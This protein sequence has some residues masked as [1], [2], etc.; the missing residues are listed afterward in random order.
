MIFLKAFRRHCIRLKIVWCEAARV[1][2]ACSLLL[3]PPH[4]VYYGDNANL[5]RG[6]S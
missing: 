1:I 3:S 6:S 2:H 5:T 4:A